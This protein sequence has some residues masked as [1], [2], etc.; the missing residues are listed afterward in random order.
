M[1]NKNT[2]EEK[3][4]ELLDEEYKLILDLVRDKNL[5]LII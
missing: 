3:Y 5:L 4:I 2:S 1:G